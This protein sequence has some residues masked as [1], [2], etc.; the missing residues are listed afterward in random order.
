M[1][2][3]LVGERSVHGGHHPIATVT[4]LSNQLHARPGERVQSPAV[5]NARYSSRAL[6]AATASVAAAS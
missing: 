4:D 6:M 5:N 1:F 2:A 3:L